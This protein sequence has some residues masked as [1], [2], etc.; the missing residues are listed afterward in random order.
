MPQEQMRLATSRP[1]NPE[2]YQA[3]LKGKYYTS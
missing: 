2:A 1:V 3:F